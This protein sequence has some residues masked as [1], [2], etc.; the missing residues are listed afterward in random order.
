MGNGSVLR[1]KSSRVR[2][3]GV[4]GPVGEDSTDWFYA[5]ATAVACTDTNII[6]PVIINETKLQLLDRNRAPSAFET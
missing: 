5:P 6:W 4:S 2:V 3:V 1:E